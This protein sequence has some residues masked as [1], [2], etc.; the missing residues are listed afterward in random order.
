MGQTTFASL[1]RS[2]RMMLPTAMF[3]AAPF[4]RNVPSGVA[5][6]PAL[7]ERPAGAEP[8]RSPS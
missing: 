1:A 4:F 7:G 6:P 3:T 5:Q 2:E 8:C